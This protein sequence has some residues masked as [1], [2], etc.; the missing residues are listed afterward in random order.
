MVWEVKQWEGTVE[1]G[2]P[3]QMVHVEREVLESTTL[4]VQHMVVM[5]ERRSPM[6]IMGYPMEAVEV[7]YRLPTKN[8]F[9]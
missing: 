4:A 1:R 9:E 7:R 2:I 5:E 3:K 6:T 8:P